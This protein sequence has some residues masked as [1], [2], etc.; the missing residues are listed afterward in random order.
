MQQ[1]SH[2]SGGR[3]FQLEMTRVGIVLEEERSPN[4]WGIPCC[5]AVVGGGSLELAQTPDALRK[6]SYNPYTH[7]LRWR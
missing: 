1:R 4:I 7:S 5:P 6:T 2:V 3:T